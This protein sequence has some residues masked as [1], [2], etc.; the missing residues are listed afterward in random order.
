MNRLLWAVLIMI[1]TGAVGAEKACGQQIRGVVRHHITGAPVEGAHAQLFRDSTSLG[2]TVT[3]SAG[4][5]I[6]AVTAAGEYLVRVR[7]ESLQTVSRIVRVGNREELV[8][9]IVMS[10]QAIALEPMR[11]VGRRTVDLLGLGGYHDRLEYYQK[12]GIGHFLTR[13]QLEI[14]TSSPMDHLLQ[15]PFVRPGPLLRHRSVQTPGAPPGNLQT[16]RLLRWAG[17][18]TGESRSIWSW[19]AGGH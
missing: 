11:V 14:G 10:D 13:E 8:L 9:E 2:A 1:G 12:L 18:A 4:I 3:D 19:S 7:H 16:P 6:I 5:F 15:I 17:S